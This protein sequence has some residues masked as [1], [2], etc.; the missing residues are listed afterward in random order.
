MTAARKDAPVIVLRLQPA[1]QTRADIHT[2]R[3]LLKVLLH[4]YG[5]R[6]LAIREEC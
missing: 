5:F 3:A 2:L 4:R 6:C 1:G